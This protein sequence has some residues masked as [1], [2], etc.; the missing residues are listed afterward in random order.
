MKTHRVSVL[1]DFCT[2]LVLVNMRSYYMCHGVFWNPPCF[3]LTFLYQALV[4]KLHRTWQPF[5][6][7]WY[8]R[9]VVRGARNVGSNVR[10]DV[11]GIVT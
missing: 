10:S 2:I 8:T 9:F 5:P 3:R 6:A 4:T 1:S 11:A 7:L